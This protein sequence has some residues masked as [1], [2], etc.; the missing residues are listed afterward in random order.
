MTDH[1]MPDHDLP[2]EFVAFLKSITSKR[3]R[4]VIDH[5]LEHG[6]VTTEELRDLYGYNHPPRAAR[7]VRELGVPLI[8][9]RV[10]G[11]DGRQ[12]GAYKFGDPADLR[13]GQFGGRK[14][15]PRLLKDALIDAQD[16]RCAICL[17]AYDAP[18][19]QIDHRVPYEV[20]G[21]SD[22]ETWAVEDYM[23]LCGSCN[24]TKSWTCEHCSN[25]QEARS[26]GICRACYWANPAGYEHIALQPV[27]RVDI[28]WTQDEIAAFDQLKQQA[29]LN[30][31]T[32]PAYIK[33]VL[34]RH[35][36]QND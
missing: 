13:R 4:T 11:S 21:D 18:H 32:L 29:D 6:Y 25:W 23:L 2:P 9:F 19:L 31:E 3:P 8:T 28:V 34:A 12:I 26:G 30:D 36:R 17:E 16:A 22:H 20:A 35:L 10:T 27:R 14:A 5:I 7:D 33:A 24:R 15:I 1:N